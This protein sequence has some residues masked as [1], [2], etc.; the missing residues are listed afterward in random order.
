MV[1]VNLR[2]ILRHFSAKVCVWEFL[3]AERM[4]KNSFFFLGWS[5]FAR[6]C[7]AQKFWRYSCPWNA[8]NK[9]VI[10]CYKTLGTACATILKHLFYLENISS[11][12]LRFTVWKIGPDG[13][14]RRKGS[15]ASGKTL[16]WPMSSQNLI[17]MD[18]SQGASTSYPFDQQQNMLQPTTEYFIKMCLFYCHDQQQNAD[19]TNNRMLQK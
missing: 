16:I 13:V 5:V 18:I 17:H 8:F 9:L 12:Y 10:V 3:F 2:T 19:M 6:G 14:K 4:Q 15:L 11:K 1:C 7:Y